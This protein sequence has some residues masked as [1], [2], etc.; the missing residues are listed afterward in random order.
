MLPL[1]AAGLLGVAALGPAGAAS[2]PAPPMPPAPP[3]PMRP[4]GR[5]V[6][7]AQGQLSSVVNMQVA[8]TVPP[9][10]DT[11]PYGV[12]IVPTSAGNLVAGDVLVTN[13]NNSAGTPGAGTTIVQIDPTTGSTSLFY[14][15]SQSLVG[16]DGIV[17]NPA[18]DILWVGDYGPANSSGV[19][20]GA[21][22][23]VDVIS[24]SGS[25]MATFDNATTGTGFFNGVWGQG[26]SDV[27]G[28]IAFYWPNAGDGTTGAGG[29]VVWR[30][31]PLSG[32]TSQPLG[33]TYTLVAKGLGYASTP[34]TTAA[35]A[36]GPQGMAYDPANGT[37]YVTDDVTNQILAIPDAASATGPGTAMVVAS[38][39]RLDSPQGIALNPTNGD[40]LVVNGAGNNDLLEYTPSGR[41]VAHR[42]LLRHQP[43]GALFGLA[44]T[45]T[46]TG[47]LVVYYVDDDT[48]T[49]WSLT[50]PPAPPAPPGPPA[51]MAVHRLS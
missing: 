21:D 44:A 16:P 14:Q 23:N 40:L 1:A 37:L 31:D 2:P 32:A 33:S 46:P 27:N 12:A 51:G 36:G 6:R 8:S 30:L 25:R 9:N 49:L 39:G 22:A 41:L 20:D 26:V 45:E 42:D 19:Y 48:N 5:P 28:Q 11:N 29:G 4:P 38:G 3:A 50:S 43:A 7:P 17:L 34:G 24:P 13:F 15:G 10:G 35:N 47:A 18:K